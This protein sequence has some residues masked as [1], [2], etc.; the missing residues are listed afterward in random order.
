MTPIPVTRTLVKPDIDGC[1]VGFLFRGRETSQAREGTYFAGMEAPLNH[2]HWRSE[3]YLFIIEDEEGKAL[4]QIAKSEATIVTTDPHLTDYRVEAHVRSFIPGAFPN[5][6]DEYCRVSRNGLVFRMQD[7][8]RYYQ[9]CLEGY[10]RVVLYRRGDYDRVVLG[11]ERFPLDQTR[12]HHLIAE[13]CGDRIRCWCDGRLVAN[14]HD[15]TYPAGLAGLRMNSIC[16]FRGIVVST[17]E[18]GHAASV[19]RMNATQRRL[20]DLRETIPKPVVWR[21]YDANALGMGTVH[22]FRLEERGAPHIFVV[23]STQ[24]LRLFDLDGKHR[25]SATAPEAGWTRNESK[26]ADVDGDGVKE[27]IS[28][29]TGGITV[30]R[31]TDGELLARTPLPAPGPFDRNRQVAT[32]SHVYPADLDG[33]GVYQSLV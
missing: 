27:I 28:L 1:P 11:E 33:T 9:L 3:T 7:L 23:T 17:W 12:Y 2:P 30:H 21:S 14:V 20:A 29:W 4:E 13:A 15:Q 32:V 5:C 26:F 31:A 16:R 24:E 6:D 19:A 25:W 18:E 22:F 10:D 8:R